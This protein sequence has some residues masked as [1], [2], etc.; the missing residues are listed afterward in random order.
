MSR[1]HMLYDDKA[2]GSI[3]FYHWTT[4]VVRL[5]HGTQHFV[6]FL[7]RLNLGIKHQRNPLH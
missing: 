7:S 3:P 2:L 5:I 1:A 6:V 4:D